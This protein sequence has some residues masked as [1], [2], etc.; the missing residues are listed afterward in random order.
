MSFTALIPNL[1]HEKTTVPVERLGRRLTAGAAETAAPQRIIDIRT[2][3][4]SLILSAAPGEEVRFLHFGGR[5]D[6]PAPLAGYRSYRHPDH[7]TEDV[8]YPAFG[9]RNYHEPALRVTHADGDL[10]TELRYVS[11]RTRKLADDNVTETVVRM[12]DAVQP[13]D[14]E[15]VYTAYARENVITTRAVIRNREKGPVTLHSFYSSA[16]PLRAEKY[17]LTHLHGAWTREAQ[18]EHTLL[19][20]GSKSI[21]STRGLRTTHAENP[22]F[23]L[24]LGNDRFDENCGEVV[25]GLAGLERKFPPQLRTRRV[26]DAHRAGGRQP[27]RLRIPAPPRRVVHDPEMIYTHSFRG[28]GGASRNLHDWAR[29]YGVWHGHVPTPTLLNSWEGAAFSFDAKT[30]TD[31]IDDAAAMGLE[32]FVLD[33]GWF[34]NKY[35]RNNDKAGLGDWEVNREKLPEGIDHIASYAHDKGAEIRHLDRTRDGQPPQR[36]GREAPRMDRPHARPRSALTRSQWLLDLS[37][38]EVQDFVFGVFDNTMRLSE[39]IDYIKWDANRCANSIGSAFQRPDEQSHFWIEYTQGLYKV[40]ERIRAKYPDVLIQSCASGGGRVEYGALRYFDEVWTSDNTE[41]LSRTRIQ[42][43]TSLFFPALVMG[44]HVSVTPNLQTGNSTPLKF[45]FDIACA[46]RLGMEL[47]PKHMTEE[48]RAEARRA[49]ADY[50]GVPR[51]RHAGRPL[52]DRFA[53]RRERLLRTGLCLERQAPG[54]GVHLLPALPEPHRP[55]V[56]HPG[57]RSRHPVHRARNEYG[58]TLLLVRRRHV[59]RRTALP[60]GSQ[61]QTLQDL[62]Q[63]RFPP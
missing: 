34:G 14:V 24:T 23:M 63:R 29:N 38:P 7:N 40:M 60:H 59:Q 37:N 51:H 30:L 44:S 16:M 3:D 62:R 56:P 15:L 36:A 54:R 32:M 42:Y 11:H 47:Q 27:R 41:A 33:D 22:S 2:D 17:L 48:E 13:L 6:D 53:L 31:M 39:H 49:I 18:V 19:T 43:G 12:T 8:A 45:R 20:H 10:N 9:G 35:P 46:G 5:I 55:A 1:S 50:K 26:S 58:G 57:T 25:A 28:A 4:I 61:P 52:P 21:A